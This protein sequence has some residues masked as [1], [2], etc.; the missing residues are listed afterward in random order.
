MSS[1]LVTGGAGFI[2]SALCERLV[3]L[4]HRV[5]SIDNY[6]NGDIRNHHEGVEYH[7]LESHQL[8]S[9]F[10][11]SDFDYIYHLG[12]YSRVEQ[13]FDDFNKVMEYNYHA[14]P[15]VVDFAN[16]GNCKLIYSGSSTKFAVEGN[17]KS[18][19]P[20]A[21]TKAQNTEYLKAFSQWNDLNHVIVYFYNVYG[22]HER[23]NGKYA[24][25]VGKFLRMYQ[26]GAHSLPV[27]YPGTQ[28]RNFTH[29]DDVVDGLYI[30]GFE[31]YGDGYGIGHDSKFS[32][33]ELTDMFDLEADMMPPAHGN[34]MDGELNSK[35]LK[36][37]GWEAKRNLYDYIEDRIFES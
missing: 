7:T 11:P 26:E 33:L 8:R 14:F 29:I 9:L 6:S 32:I 20:Y 12:E 28:L 16:D 30:A 13:S 3:E 31:G 21:Y 17:G 1:V 23:S 18:M 35:K 19:S 4:G 34:R 36:D 22:D 27:T 37:L 10:D 24:T 15:H 5:T 25:V 2:G